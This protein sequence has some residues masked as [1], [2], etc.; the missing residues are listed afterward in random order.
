MLIDSGLSDSFVKPLSSTPFQIAVEKQQ[1]SRGVDMGWKG[2][3]HPT[4]DAG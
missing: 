1:R 4:H 3:L 2:C